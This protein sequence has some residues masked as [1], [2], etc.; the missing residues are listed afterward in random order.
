[1]LVN[2]TTMNERSRRARQEYSCA[3]LK[4]LRAGHQ[5]NLPSRC[6]RWI[7]TK[8]NKGG[9][10]RPCRP[11]PPGTLKRYFGF[12]LPRESRSPVDWWIEFLSAA[13]GAFGA[14]IVPWPVVAVDGGASFSDF[15][16]GL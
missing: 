16:A 9:R 8:R 5:T 7:E 14:P 2:G 13:D 11:S 4:V 10:S 6:E 12:G 3:L 15:C 1:M